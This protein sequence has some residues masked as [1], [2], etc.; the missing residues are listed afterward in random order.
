MEF[1]LPSLQKGTNSSDKPGP[2]GSMHLAEWIAHLGLMFTQVEA[3]WVI[4]VKVEKG[5]AFHQAA[6]L[7]VMKRIDQKSAIHLFSLI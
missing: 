7:R 1:L 4:N 3:S 2:L 6:P 5:R